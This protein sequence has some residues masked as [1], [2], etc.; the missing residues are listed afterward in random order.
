MS[1]TASHA[2][3]RERREIAVAVA[4]D[5]LDLGVQLGVRRAAVEERQLVAALE[6]GVGDRA[7]E[8][9][10]AAEEEELH[11]SAARPVEQAVDLVLGVVV[12]DARRAR[13]RPSS[14]RCF[15]VSTA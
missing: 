9:P 12:D 15:I 3:P 1:T 5:P 11:A 10:R 2:R 13:R 7:T 14:P 8:E 4:D 6:R